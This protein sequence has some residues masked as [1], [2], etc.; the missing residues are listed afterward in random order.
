[1]PLFCCFFLFYFLKNSSFLFLILFLPEVLDCLYVFLNALL[2]SMVVL[3][4]ITGIQTVG[5]ILM[6]ALLITPA[7]TARYWTD[8]LGVMAVLSV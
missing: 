6:V 4:V 8:R 7:I 2:S 5:V 3:V 1:M